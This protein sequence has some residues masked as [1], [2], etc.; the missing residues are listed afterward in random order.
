MLAFLTFWLDTVEKAQVLLTTLA[1]A[2]FR[3]Y[4]RLPV[5]HDSVAVKQSNWI[6]SSLI[7]FFYTCAFSTV[8]SQKVIH[9][10]DIWCPLFLVLWCVI[11]NQLY[12]IEIAYKCGKNCC[13]ATADS[14]SKNYKTNVVCCQFQIRVIMSQLDPGHLWVISNN[15]KSQNHDFFFHD[16]FIIFH[17]YW[18]TAF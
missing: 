2:F 18:L 16:S 13:T 12:Y 4:S 9:E 8:T 14:S 10:K 3:S 6:Q 5:G 11:G 1:M 7:W 17:Q 15:I